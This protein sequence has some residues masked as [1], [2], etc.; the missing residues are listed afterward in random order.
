MNRKRIL[1]VH[2]G[3]T[4]GGVPTYLG[5]LALLLHDDADVTCF[6]SFE[7]LVHRLRQTSTKVIAVPAWLARRR[8]LRTVVAPLALGYIVLRHRI[9]IVALSGSMEGIL[10]LPARLLGCRVYYTVHLTLQAESGRLKHTLANSVICSTLRFAHRVICVSEAVAAD[11]VK[12]I[13]SKRVTVIQNWVNLP[14]NGVTQLP[15]KRENFG[16]ADDKPL[17]LLFIGRLLPHKGTSLILDA[18]RRLNTGNCVRTVSL[19]VVGEGESR[20][21]LERQAKGLAVRFVGFQANPTN[22]YQNADLFINPTLGPEGLP[23]VS[24]EAMSHGL[25]CIL[26]DLPVHKEITDG[27]KYAPLFRS[28][29]ADDLCSQIRL[30]LLAPGLL[31]LYGRLAKDLVKARYSADIARKRYA[32]E[33]GL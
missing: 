3:A 7:D 14:L 15:A 19:T 30:F 11:V 29:D 24:L 26:S 28:G 31:D 17:R 20:S 9:R 1:L 10:A 6:C 27:G 21:E 4:V 23:L 25:P 32:E 5:N 16:S 33:F 8:L 12:H 22:F 2:L 18:M 13:P